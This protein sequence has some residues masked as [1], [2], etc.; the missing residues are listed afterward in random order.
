MPEGH[1]I[2]TLDGAVPRIIS[3]M[4]IKYRPQNTTTWKTTPWEKIDTNTDYACQF[5]LQKLAENT[6]NEIVVLA[7]TNNKGVKT[8][9]GNFT[10]APPKKLSAPI[11]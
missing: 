1:T 5:T 9:K 7:K 2:E 6:K 8:Q 3:Q 4:M 11:H 10:N